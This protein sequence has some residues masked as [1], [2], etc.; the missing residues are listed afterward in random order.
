MTKTLSKAVEKIP[1]LVKSEQLNPWLEKLKL[2]FSTCLQYIHSITAMLIFDENPFT[3]DIH[4]FIL[5]FL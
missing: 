3:H 5:A 1:D 4:S 2:D